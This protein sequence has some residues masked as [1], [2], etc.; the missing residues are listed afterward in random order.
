MSEMILGARDILQVDATVIVGFLILFT[1][2]GAVKIRLKQSEPELDQLINS[3]LMTGIIMATILPFAVSAASI[4]TGT[5]MSLLYPST[6]Q[7][8]MTI[9]ST[10]AL[11]GFVVLIGSMLYMFKKQFKG[12]KWSKTSTSNISEKQLEKIPEEYRK[13]LRDFSNKINTHLENHPEV[14]P[15]NQSMIG[16]ARQIEDITTGNKNEFDYEKQKNIEAKIGG[17]IQKVLKIL[18]E[19][20]E[21]TATIAT[22][23]PLGKLAGKEVLEI[24][25]AIQGIRRYG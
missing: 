18:P 15:I 2:G 23:G 10:A 19:K 4:I 17:I 20:A 16:L 13:S 12:V 5:F 6:L 24:K 21:S 14:K 25:N 3:F 9:G 1:V 8:T 11:I 22:L 7:I